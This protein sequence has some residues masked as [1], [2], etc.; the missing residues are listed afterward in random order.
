MVTE[1]PTG[2]EVG[3]R[4]VIEGAEL[5]M[6]VLAVAVLPS[7]KFAVNVKLIPLAKRLLTLSD[8]KILKLLP[9]VTAKFT[10]SLP[11]LS[12]EVSNP[13]AAPKV[14]KPSLGCVFHTPPGVFVN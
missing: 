7:A 10:E 12:N 11:A 14:Q 4:L 6:V 8:A 13:L 2:P 5:V 1:A 9:S 3:E